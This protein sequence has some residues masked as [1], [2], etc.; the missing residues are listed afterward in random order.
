M[1]VSRLT[2]VVRIQDFPEVGAPT[3]GGGEGGRQHMML[4]NF[5]KNC[6]KLKEF[7]AA[8]LKILLCRSVT[9]W[10]PCTGLCNQCQSTYRH[11]SETLT[12]EG[13]SNSNRAVQDALWR[14][15]ARVSWRGLYPRTTIIRRGS[16]G[17]V[18][19]L[20]RFMAAAA[21]DRCTPAKKGTGEGISLE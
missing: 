8:A 3:L 1:A 6:M 13:N 18:C 4:P 17:R 15:P 14:R 7:G 9:D 2:L 11:W 20:R 10:S 12:R 5:S 21:P 19:C 16:F